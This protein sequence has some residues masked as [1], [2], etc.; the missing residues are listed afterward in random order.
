MKQLEAGVKEVED[1]RG[2]KNSVCL[3]ILLR[4][5]LL[6]DKKMAEAST[7]HKKSNVPLRSCYYSLFTFFN[8]QL[9]KVAPGFLLDCHSTITTT[10]KLKSDPLSQEIELAKHCSDAPQ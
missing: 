8:N 9:L 6:F 4:T 10:P 3:H 1:L 7:Q 2:G 5:I